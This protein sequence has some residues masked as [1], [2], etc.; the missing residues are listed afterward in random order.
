MEQMINIALCFNFSDIIVTK[1][2]TVFSHIDKSCEWLTY[3]VGSLIFLELPSLFLS[4]HSATR[5]TPKNFH[6]L[7]MLGTDTNKVK[8]KNKTKN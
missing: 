6:I 3:T 2:L 1:N 8:K 5:S 4:H 7:Y